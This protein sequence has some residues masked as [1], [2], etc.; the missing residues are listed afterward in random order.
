MIV[1][2][3]LHEFVEPRV[4]DFRDA[5]IDQAVSRQYSDGQDQ[6]GAVPRLPTTIISDSHISRRFGDWIVEFLDLGPLSVEAKVW[7]SDKLDQI[8]SRHSP[9]PR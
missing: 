4:P 7:E 2:G 3:I 1:V 6:D 5:D 8:A 9:K